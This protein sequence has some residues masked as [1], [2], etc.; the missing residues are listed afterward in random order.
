MLVARRDGSPGEKLIL[1]IVGIHSNGISYRVGG[2]GVSSRL[3]GPTVY[4]EVSIVGQRD[5]VDD[6]VSA[7][8]LAKVANLIV[9][10]RAPASA[11][12]SLSKRL[13]AP[14]VSVADFR[15]EGAL[16]SQGRVGHP[17]ITVRRIG[18][19][20]RLVEVLTCSGHL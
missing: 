17:V 9:A 12:L 6:L 11:R 5:I 14:L 7:R 15:P 2:D 18:R 20:W 3:A 19:L 13:V 16:E 10:E 1:R 4:V 8:V